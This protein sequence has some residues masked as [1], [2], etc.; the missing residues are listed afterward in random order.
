MMNKN[1]FVIGTC[2]NYTH[3]GQG[4][5]K[6]DGYPIFVKGIIRGEKRKFKS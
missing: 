6:I 5:V 2:E 1:E 4:V 3:D